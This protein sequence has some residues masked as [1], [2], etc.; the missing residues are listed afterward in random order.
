MMK[1]LTLRSLSVLRNWL[2]P[3]RAPLAPPPLA[4][5]A[6]LGGWVGEDGGL[7]VLRALG[8][9]EHLLHVVAGDGKPLVVVDHNLRVQGAPE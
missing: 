5:A 7:E 9:A 2:S 6:H 4:G 1:R 8:L 3:P